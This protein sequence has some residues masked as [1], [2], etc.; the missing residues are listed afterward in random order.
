MLNVIYVLSLFLA[1]LCVGNWNRHQKGL[2]SSRCITKF[3]EEGTPYSVYTVRPV[4]SRPHIEW[5]PSIK[6]TQL[7]SQNFL[8]TFTVNSQWL[9]FWSKC[10]FLSWVWGEGWGNSYVKCMVVPVAPFRGGKSSFG[11]YTSKGYRALGDFFVVELQIFVG[12][13]SG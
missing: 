8:L 7:T 4:F 3:E 9:I 6:W 13:K 12:V 11:T 10:S 2:Q 1:R 5:T